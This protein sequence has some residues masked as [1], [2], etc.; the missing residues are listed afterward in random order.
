MR[1]LVLI[2][3]CALLMG[4]FSGSLVAAPESVVGDW[5][6]GFKFNEQWVFIKARF[7]LEN[8][9]LT[10]TVD[11]PLEGLL[12]QTF[13]QISAEAVHLHFELLWDSGVII[14]DGQYEDGAITGICQQAGRQ[15]SFQFVR[16]AA[17]AEEV[18]DRYVGSYQ[19]NPHRAVLI[20]KTDAGLAYHEFGVGRVGRLSPLS[21]TTFFSGP[22]ALIDLPVEVKVKFVKSRDGSV[23]G[24]VW[25]E[26]G[27]PERYAAKN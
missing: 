24:L 1:L 11:L 27:F 22:L 6:G 7:K 23:A 19:F 12:G 14:F 13:S 9:A 5:M 3:A 21:E 16:P 18:M 2:S 10:A 25:Q 26:R 8:E 17:V 4:S 20:E 15:G